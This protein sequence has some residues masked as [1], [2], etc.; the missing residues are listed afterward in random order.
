MRFADIPGLLPIKKKLIQSVQSNKMAHAQLIAGK[1][2]ALNLPLAIAYATYI[3]C[4]DRQP[5]DACGVCSACVKNLKY[6]HPDL[7]FVFPL[8]N[9]KNDKDADRFK[10]EILKSWRAFLLEQ[11]FGNLSNWTSY[12]GGENKQAL[13][14]R[15]ES[16]E[17]IKTLSLKSFES[18]YKVMI[19]WQPEYMHG[20]AANGILKILEEPPQNTYFLLVSNAHDQLLPTILSRTQLV[21]VPQLTDDELSQYLKDHTDSSETDRTN[22]LQVADGDLNLAMQLTEEGEESINQEFFGT[23]MRACFKKDYGQLVQMGDDFHQLDKLNQQNI[24]YYSIGM[25]RE[26][27]LSIAGTTQMNRTRGAE[28]KFIQDFSKVL[29]VLK[30]EKATQL[31]SQA[32]Y[33]LERNGSPKMTFVSLSLQISDLLNP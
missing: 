5:D 4:Q 14:S 3:H 28:L 21:Q 20:S 10:A 30:I 12:Y 33:Y 11:P 22:I 26:S 15:D 8:S 32:S 16:R 27:L 1:E 31:M 25:M 29:D 6:I 9:V 18:Q 17:I 2:G 23:W 13:I 24:L 7:H 19:I